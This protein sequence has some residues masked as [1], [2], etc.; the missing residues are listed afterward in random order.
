VELGCQGAATESVARK[1][2]KGEGI[3]GKGSGIIREWGM[4]DRR[5]RMWG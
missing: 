2:R 5:W 4:K 3:R 1:R